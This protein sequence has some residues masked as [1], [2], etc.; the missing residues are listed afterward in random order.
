[1]RQPHTC[2]GEKENM[3]KKLMSIVCLLLFAVSGVAA[4]PAE[5]GNYV[6]YQP[7]VIHGPY[8]MKTLDSVTMHVGDTYVAY[9]PYV[10][11]SNQGPAYR[12]RLDFPGDIL[13]KTQIDRISTYM[14]KIQ[15]KAIAKGKGS[16][17]VTTIAENV[18]KGYE[19]D[20][21]VI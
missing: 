13:Q 2:G 17:I 9:A 5:H 8:P 4:W 10:V 21:N 7:V 11:R 3:I 14:Q 19:V 6:I 15:F 12:N 16:I 18:T 1:M 20:V